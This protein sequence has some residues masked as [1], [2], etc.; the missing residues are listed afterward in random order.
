MAAE[1]LAVETTEG[2][3]ARLDRPQWR[4]HIKAGATGDVLFLASEGYNNREELEQ[5]IR[6]VFTSGCP[7]YLVRPDGSQ[8]QLR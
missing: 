6:L 8:E 7:V 4:A 2:T 5:A 3:E 1:W